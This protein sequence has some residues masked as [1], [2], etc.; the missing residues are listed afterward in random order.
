[1]T[2]TDPSILDRAAR[3]VN[4]S[5][6]GGAAYGIGLAATNDATN[7]AKMPAAKVLAELHERMR[8]AA[9]FHMGSYGPDRTG[10]H[11]AQL[12]ELTQATARAEREVLRR[13]A[14]FDLILAGDPFWKDVR[15]LAETVTHGGNLLASGNVLDRLDRC[16]L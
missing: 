10:D 5:D 6:S 8:R 1:M 13:M 11:V 4:P 2:N 15:E 14:L 7:L 3:T 16:G 12:I 9:D